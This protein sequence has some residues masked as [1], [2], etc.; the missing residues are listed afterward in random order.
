MHW[1]TYSWTGHERPADSERRNPANAVP[2]LDVAE[3]LRKPA[4]NVV[5]TH[6]IPDGAADAYGWLEAELKE[7]PRSPRD[8]PPGP[9]MDGAREC[10]ERGADVVWGYYSDKGR[11]VSRALIGCPREGLACPYGE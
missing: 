1:H 6:Q 4:R 3:W 5:A 8:L 7:Y 11:Y 2:P 9:Q 10:L